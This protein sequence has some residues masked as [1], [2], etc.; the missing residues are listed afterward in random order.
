M[1]PNPLF[2][3]KEVIDENIGTYNVTMLTTFYDR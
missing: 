2:T 3:P 1:Q